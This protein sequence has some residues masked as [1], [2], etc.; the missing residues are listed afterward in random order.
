MTRMMP[1][2]MGRNKME[3]IQA[4]RK[5]SLIERIVDKTISE[6]ILLAVTSSHTIDMQCAYVFCIVTHRFTIIN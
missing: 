4:N 1:F 2:K 5:Q 3:K 6:A